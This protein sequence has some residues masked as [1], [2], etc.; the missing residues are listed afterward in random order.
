[1]KKLNGHN[2]NG[3]N[4][5]GHAMNSTKSNGQTRKQL[6]VVSLFTGAG[7]LDLG[8]K[9]AGYKCV[10]AS[11]IMPQAEK[12]FK[13]NFPTTPFICKDIRLFSKEEI[14]ELIGDETIDV[15]IGG[16][17]CQGFSNMGNKNSSD[18]RNYLFEDYVKIVNIIKPKCFLFENVKGIST[19]FEGRFFDK[20]INSFLEIGYNIS[21]SLIDSSK[22]GVPQKRERIIIFGSR[23]DR[24]FKFPKPNMHSFGKLSSYMNVGEAINDLINKDKIIPNHIVLK[25][26]EI[27]VQR[28]ALI[29]EGG[30]LPKP[31]N[32][33][34]EIR[35]K[36]FW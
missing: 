6:K 15:I 10:F 19:M 33:P 9:E 27:V 18:P 34:V 21:Y 7:G 25:H 16:P 20:I 24:L 13:L 11:D 35:R 2:S 30:K 32:L 29:E 36:K 1:M 8:F 3:P 5:N 12:T 14:K 26:N 17:P 31:E 28:Y 23:I 4:L 22:Y